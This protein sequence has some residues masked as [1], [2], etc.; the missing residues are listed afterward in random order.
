MTQSDLESVFHSPVKV[1]GTQVYSHKWNVVLKSLRQ[2]TDVGQLTY[3]EEMSSGFLCS[4]QIQEL[5][6]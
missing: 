2:T 4:P 3:L 5:Q 6:S 1:I